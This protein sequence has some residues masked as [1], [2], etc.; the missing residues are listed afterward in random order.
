MGSRRTIT[1][2]EGCGAPVKGHEAAKFRPGELRIYAGGSMRRRHI[3]L[4]LLL[5]AGVGSALAQPSARPAVV[6]EAALLAEARRLFALGVSNARKGLWPEARD[7]FAAAYQLAPRP[8]VLFNLAGA[9]VR[10]GQLLASNANYHRFA[11]SDEPSIAAVHRRVAAQQ[12]THIEARIPRLRVLIEGL[13]PED[14]VL[15]DA[16]RVYPNELD[17]DLWLDP[18]PHTLSVHRPGGHE[19]VRRFI[20]MES[21]RRIMQLRSP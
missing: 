17:L 7:A 18:G 21:E 12:I 6:G 15:I 10:T 8:A 11:G 1:L 19:E 4:V 5:G 14:R 2:M 9:Q 3:F 16:K 20:L 13:L